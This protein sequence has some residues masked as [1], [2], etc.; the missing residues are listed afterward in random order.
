[1]SDKFDEA[2]EELGTEKVDDFLAKFGLGP[3]Y[4]PSEPKKHKCVACGE[5]NAVWK[6]RH[7]DTDM[8]CMALCCPDCGHEVEQ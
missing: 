3:K 4:V 6:E 5:L 1:V 7:A 2:R 8:N